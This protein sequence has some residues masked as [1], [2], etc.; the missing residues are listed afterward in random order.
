MKNMKRS[1]KIEKIAYKGFI[2]FHD[3]DE[4]N[5]GILNYQSKRYYSE[6]NYNC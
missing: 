3:F 5:L 4:N 1:L 2:K 6:K